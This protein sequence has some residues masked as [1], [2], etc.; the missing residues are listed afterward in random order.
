MCSPFFKHLNKIDAMLGAAVQ[1]FSLMKSLIVTAEIR[2]KDRE[3]LGR[4]VEETVRVPLNDA[5]DTSN[6]SLDNKH[7]SLRS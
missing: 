7:S 3:T 4:H 5:F 2:L 1:T 6:T